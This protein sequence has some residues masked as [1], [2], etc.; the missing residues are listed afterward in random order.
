MLTIGEVSW[1]GWSPVLQGF[2]C[3][4]KYKKT[5]IISAFLTSTGDH[6]YG[7]CYW[8]HIT[9]TKSSQLTLLTKEIGVCQSSED[10]GFLSFVA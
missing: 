9:L 4:A 5:N 2:N 3:F 7:K 8:F 1:Y 10:K 6:H